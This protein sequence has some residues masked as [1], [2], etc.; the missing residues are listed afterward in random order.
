MSKLFTLGI[1]GNL[2]FGTQSFRVE[3]VDVD[4]FHHKYTCNLFF[5]WP[6]INK[7]NIIYFA[8]AWKK[9]YEWI[10]L[11]QNCN[12]C[13]DNSLK[14]DSTSH[15]FDSRARLNLFEQV[16]VT[17]HTLHLIRLLPTVFVVKVTRF[18][19]VLSSVCRIKDV[20][21]R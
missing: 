2:S 9:K 20:T 7:F 4:V 15:R 12:K 13:F 6:V 14:Y 18:A 19:S 16:P 1:M 11:S 5:L 10:K 8:F 3:H 17:V 21:F